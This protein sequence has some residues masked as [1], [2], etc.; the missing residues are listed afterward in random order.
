MR[1]KKLIMISILALSLILVGCASKTQYDP[2]AQ[3]LTENGVKMYGAYGCSAC[4]A[5]KKIFKDSFK[6]VNYIE[7]A[8]P[9]SDEP[10]EVC[11]QA[12]IESYPTWEFADGTRQAGVI[13]VEQLSQIS[14]CPLPE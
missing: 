2:L 12:N 5:Q 11:K 3:C 14:G 8:I 6:K 1:I 13:P 9:G 4:S 10:T 7:C